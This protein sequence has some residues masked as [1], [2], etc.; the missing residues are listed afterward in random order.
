MP[1][2]QSSF[3]TNGIEYVRAVAE[4]ELELNTIPKLRRWR[5]GP[6]CGQGCLADSAPLTDWPLCTPGACRESAVWVERSGYDVMFC[7]S[8]AQAVAPG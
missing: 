4:R 5:G 2:F 1:H 8:L 6:S 3:I 7:W